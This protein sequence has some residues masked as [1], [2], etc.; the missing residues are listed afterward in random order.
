MLAAVLTKTGKADK[1]FR[2]KEVP[3]P[4]LSEG[5]VKIKVEAFGLNFADVM[6]RQGL[7]QDCP[8]LPTVLG[9]DVVGSVVEVAPGVDHITAGDRVVALTRFGG[10]AQYAVSD[11]RAC[12]VIDA[13]YDPVKA[14]A[15]STQYC[16]AWYCLHEM[17]RLYHGDKVLIHAAAGGLGT[18]MVQL[19]L[20]F[21]YTVFA[22][23]GSDEKVA[24][25]QRAGVHYPINYNTKDYEQEIKN[26][27]KVERPLDAVFN[28]VGGTLVPKDLRLLNAGGRE[29]LCGAAKIVNASIFGKI[30]ELIGFGFY[31]PIQFM[32]KSRG[33]I[34]VNMLQVADN[35]PEM[36][37]RCLQN[38]V[39]LAQQGILDPHVGGYY[40][41]NELAKAH[42]LLE[43]RQSTGKI[44]IH[45]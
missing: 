5:T 14:T 41:I 42:E 28:S 12:A 7:Y 32:M 6:A 35:K 29:V 16:T 10:Y 21:Q 36:I 18:A 13:N 39:S 43:K 11:A 19:A 45:W 23:A 38:V 27:T 25:L 40:S 26:L 2:I 17:V 44:A 4:T 8:P 24:S 31:H 30:K 34:G 9:Y 1:A 33:L 20:H 22:T 3:E 37:S 15:L